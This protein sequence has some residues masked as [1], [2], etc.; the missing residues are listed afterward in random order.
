MSNHPCNICQVKK[1]IGKWIQTELSFA[2]QLELALQLEQEAQEIRTW[3]YEAQ[4]GGNLPA[5]PL[6]DFQKSRIL[7]N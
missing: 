4:R 7:W 5:L 2:E 3:V 1:K 6:N